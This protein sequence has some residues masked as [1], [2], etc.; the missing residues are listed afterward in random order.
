MEEVGS[1]LD[2][3]QPGESALA[4][5]TDGRNLKLNG[6]GS[7]SS[8]NWV[9]DPARQVDRFVIYYREGGA[10]DTARLY[11]GDYV[12]AGPSPEA[13]RSV[14]TFEGAEQVGVTRLSWPEFADTGANPVRYISRPANA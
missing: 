13:G 11:R 9:I 10:G 1:L 7:G 12:G 8:G 2:L 4:V 3:L 5:L 14:V 6:D